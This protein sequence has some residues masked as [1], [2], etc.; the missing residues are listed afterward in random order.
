[1][2]DIPVPL[3]NSAYERKNDKNFVPK[4]IKLV[5]WNSSKGKKGN[6]GF[7]WND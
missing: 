2:P 4:K 1:L 6:Q 3:G 5:E 7:S